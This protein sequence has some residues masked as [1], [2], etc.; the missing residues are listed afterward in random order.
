MGIHSPTSLQNAVFFY[1][2]MYFCL[3]GGVEHRELKLSQFEV[4]EVV[5][6]VVEKKMIKCL[7][8]T[9]HGSKN[10]QGLVHQVQL[11]NKVVTHYADLAIGE[12]CFVHLFEL[13]S[14]LLPEESKCKDVFY[15]KPKKKFL[16]DDK[17]WYFA[18][19]VGH[20]ILSRKLKDMFVAAGM[21][22]S[23]IHNH[24]LRASG[25]TRMY[26]EG[27]PEKLIMERSGH[28]SIGG[29]RSYERTTDVQKKEVSQVLSSGKAVGPKCL[30]EIN[31][32]TAMEC[33]GSVEKLLV[34]TGKENKT[35]NLQ[36]LH[37]CHL[38]FSIHN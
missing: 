27:V 9:E 21:D 29:I 25:I 7:I 23:D 19:A 13:Y 4:K 1:S 12:W 16:M 36:N 37:G 11:E 34:P 14:S 33:P 6:P 28:L 31:A 35:F 30:K 18:V 32:G 8:Y 20:N 26:T 22:S 5:D 3:R 38:N 24:S 2:G 10:R 17:C 15:C